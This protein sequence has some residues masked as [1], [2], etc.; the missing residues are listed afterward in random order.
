M[1]ISVR[2]TAVCQIKTQVHGFAYIAGKIAWNID[3]MIAYN[4]IIS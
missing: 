3:D 1:A 4:E 2:N